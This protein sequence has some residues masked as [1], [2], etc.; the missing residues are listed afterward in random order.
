MARFEGDE[1]KRCMRNIAEVLAAIT[2]LAGPIYVEYPGLTP[3]QLRDQ[4]R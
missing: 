3:S 4:G 2:M 1:L